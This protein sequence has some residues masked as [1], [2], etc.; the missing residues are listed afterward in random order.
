MSKMLKYNELMQPLLNALEKLGGS[1]TIDEIASS[2]I[3]SLNLPDDITSQIHDENKSGQTEIEYRLAWARTYLKKYG[4]IENSERGVWS[5]TGRYQ[6]GM[7]INSGEVVKHVKE[8]DRSKKEKKVRTDEPDEL[9]L[10][11]GWKEQL[12]QTILG[13]SPDAFE[14][15]TKRILRESGFVQVEVTGSSGDGGIDGKG[16]VRINGILSYHVVFQCKRYKGSVG[17]NQIR[18]FRGAMIG[19]ADKGLFV[20]TGTFTREAIREATRD[21]APPIDLIDG[22]ELAERI[23]NLRLGVIVKMVEEIELDKE[24]FSKI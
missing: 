21:G 1:G 4:L 19:R 7:Q 2:V 14:R 16:I 22:D 9:E 23:K 24:W 10:E 5:F 18:D 6:K 3:Q 11:M 13:L 12:H 20:T 17:P 8:M 15:L